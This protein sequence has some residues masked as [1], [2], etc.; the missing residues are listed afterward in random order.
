MFDHPHAVEVSKET[1]V[2]FRDKCLSLV[3]ENQPEIQ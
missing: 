3:P 1:P 2:V